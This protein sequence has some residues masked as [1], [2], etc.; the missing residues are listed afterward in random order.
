MA[1]SAHPRKI[2]VLG[3]GG[4]G[5]A[6]AAKLLELGHQVV[7]GTRDSQVTLGRTQPDFMGIEPFGQWLADYPGIELTTFR[8]AA[9][10]ADLVINGIDGGH[11]LEVLGGLA[12][13]L[14]GKILIDYAVPYVYN[15]E[16]AHPWPTPWGVMPA[17]DPVDHDSLGERIQRALPATKV[18][19]AGVTQEQE[20]V[21][22]PRT[23]AD[24]DHTLLVAG[25]D[26]DAKEQVTALL[27]AYGWTDVL[28]LGPIV[29][30]RGMEMYAH[31]HCAIGFAVGGRF[32]I[33]VV[34]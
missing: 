16:R 1:A 3:T 15:P 24:G 5:R 18:V 2:A 12:D 28:D 10:C 25:D 29:C 19:K 23:V 34:R 26:A 9:A 14:A 4:G 30:S 27:R 22:A 6:H 7:V 13:Q 33:K 20:V 17:L 8:D 31:L 32:G 21:V 11:A